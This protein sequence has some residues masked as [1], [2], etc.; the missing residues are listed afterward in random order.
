MPK[1]TVICASCGKRMRSAREQHRFTLAGG[2]YA[3]LDDV[4]VYTCTCGERSVAI[5]KPLPLLRTIAAAVIAKRA[6]LSP[7]EVRFLRDHLQLAARQ[8]AGRLGV[9]PETV[10]RWENGHEPIGPTADRLLRTLVALQDKRSAQFDPERLAAIEPKEQG[11]L[12]L[13]IRM[14]DGHWHLAA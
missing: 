8:L 9:T 13:T 1:N 11:P 4:K 7:Q 2:W 14:D 10:S 5:E 12:Q 6:R 3:L